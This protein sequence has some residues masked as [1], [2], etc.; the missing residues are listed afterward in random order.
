MDRSAGCVGLR[1]RLAQGWTAGMS[2]SY[3]APDADTSALSDGCASARSV[4][5]CVHEPEAGHAG[6]VRS[7]HGQ[8]PADVVRGGFA[9]LPAASRI[10]WRN[11]SL[12]GASSRRSS[13]NRVR[14][15][16]LALLIQD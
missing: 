10:T 2:A 7:D 9:G 6:E 12:V 11:P 3:R 1:I 15:G 13:K 4:P 5:P 8:R 14:S 16:M